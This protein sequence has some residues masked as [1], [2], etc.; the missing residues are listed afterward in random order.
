M[1][2]LEEFWEDI[3][4]KYVNEKYS[5]MSLAKEYNCNRQTVRNLLKSHNVEIRDAKHQNKK[6]VSKEIQ[7]KVIYNYTVLKKGLVPSGKP[8]GL[9]QRAVKTILQENGVYI[10]NYVESKDNLRKYTIDDDYFK[11]QSHNMAYILGL[12]ASDGSVSSKE[13]GIFIQL[14]ADDKK[15]LEDINRELKNTRPVKV[16]SCVGKG[17][18]EREIAKLSFWSSTIKKDLAHYGIVPNK[19]FILK[20]PELLLPEYCISY[21]RGYFDGD[22]CIV[23]NN[24]TPSFFIGGASKDIIQWMRD[25][26][27][28]QYNIQTV[29]R[30]VKGKLS[31]NRDWYEITYYGDRA[32]Q[33]FNILYVKDSLYMERKYKKFLSLMK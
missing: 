14:K 22:G 23:L 16:Y 32:R 6:D 20:P 30:T 26:L 11:T 10:R 9:S 27:S 24:Y 12:L 5:L 1:S 17:E 29:L 31:D 21:I 8:F 25:F 4:K 2:K 18:K 3:Y 13:N 33:I 7:E 19:T 15:I 28:T